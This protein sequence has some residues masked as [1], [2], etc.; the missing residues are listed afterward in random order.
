MKRKFEKYCYSQKFQQM[1]ERILRSHKKRKIQEDLEETLMQEVE[2]CYE[3]QMK[4]IQNQYLNQNIS[5]Q[6]KGYVF[7]RECQL[8]IRKQGFTCTLS[9]AREG[10]TI[11]HDHGID[12]IGV[13]ENGIQ[14]LAQFKRWK[15]PVPMK[16]IRAFAHVISKYTGFVG[17]FVSQGEYTPEVLQEIQTIKEPIILLSEIG[18]T[19]QELI[20]QI[21]IPKKI[22]RE[23]R[24][25]VE[26]QEITE[27]PN[28][29]PFLG[30]AKFK[31]LFEYAETEY[32]QQ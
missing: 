27:I 3:S 31:G 22:I 18:P 28:M 12:A 2:T 7:E 11:L 32:I 24:I 21:K 13:N 19:F 4:D 5:P 17:I 25:K 1:T 10:S 30:G 16:E 29:I 23:K 15:T 8:K 6:E 20:S 26:T 14:Y 9:A